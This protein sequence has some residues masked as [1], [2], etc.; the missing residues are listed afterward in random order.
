MEEQ[1]GRLF[2]EIEER[3]EDTLKIDSYEIFASQA[4]ITTE[5][6]CKRILIHNGTIE[7]AHT[8]VPLGD[9]FYQY[10]VDVKSLFPQSIQIAIHQVR[11][12]GNR[13][14]HDSD[15]SI[16]E[17]EFKI[18]RRSFA[19]IVR[20]FYGYFE[21]KVSFLL[22]RKI[23][24][25]LSESLRVND[26]YES[27]TYLFAKNAL[28]ESNPLFPKECKRLVNNILIDILIDNYG[29]VPS[30]LFYKKENDDLNI[31]NVLKQL[32]QEHIISPDV[33]HH[34]LI[35]FNFFLDSQKT[36]GTPLSNK[37]TIPISIR[38][39]FDH[40]VVWRYPPVN[41][42]A[43]VKLSLPMVFMEVG[44]VALTILVSYL[45]FKNGIVAAQFGDSKVAAIVLIS[46]S[47]TIFIGGYTYHIIQHIFS[48][49]RNH[50]LVK[51][52]AILLMIL[53]IMGTI[54][55]LY[56]FN[57]LLGVEAYYRENTLFLMASF[58]LLFFISRS[59]MIASK[60]I[61]KQNF[62]LK[63]LSYVLTA[64]AIAFGASMIILPNV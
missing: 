13:A 29:K 27:R 21:R 20:F 57:V 61:K 10:S 60:Q 25:V 17:N 1:A 35:L 45:W 32:Q 5:G 9:M 14:S 23:N 43:D 52:N 12:I 4:R 31:N 50:A 3:I 18:T 58:L 30:Q 63:L 28:L 46:V 55:A 48:S 26:F 42:K 6:I 11:L 2:L 37:I 19:E 53:G 51:F 44:I 8:V 47:I 22:N 64:L 38:L 36:I 34:I 39:A 7:T 24:N 56:T 33:A 62:V 54:I 15:V 16:T 49:F 59:M 40:I 41:D